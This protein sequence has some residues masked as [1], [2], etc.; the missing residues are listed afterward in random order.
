MLFEKGNSVSKFIITWHWLQW[1]LSAEIPTWNV[2]YLCFD[3]TFVIGILIEFEF[4]WLFP[5]RFCF[6]FRPTNFDIAMINLILSQCLHR[7]R[8]LNSQLEC[9]IQEAMAEL[10]R[11][12]TASST[13]PSTS[14]RN[15]KARTSKPTSTQPRTKPVKI[16]PAPPN[17]TTHLQAKYLRQSKWPYEQLCY[18]RNDI[19][20]SSATSSTKILP[21]SFRL[22]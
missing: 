1:L 6:F 11:S 12:V 2:F 3:C 14:N 7:S 16:A 8:K 18:I 13:V 17:S 19:Y 20:F 10:D 4:Y 21:A 5:C 22:V 9:A 15:H